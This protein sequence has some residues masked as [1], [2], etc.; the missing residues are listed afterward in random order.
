MNHET[1]DWLLIDIA[2][3]G[4]FSEVL[5]EKRGAWNQIDFERRKK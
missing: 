2:I 4:N 1:F 5:F 3:N